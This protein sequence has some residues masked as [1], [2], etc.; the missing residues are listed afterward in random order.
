MTQVEVPGR[1]ERKKA[2][3]RAR[4]IEEATA[5]FRQRGYQATTIEDI[6]EAADVAPR[7]FY[8]YFDAKVDVALAQFEEWAERHYEAMAARPAGETPV[9]MAQ[10]ALVELARMGYVTSE[11]LRDEH[12]IPYP[13]IAAAVV[14]SETEPEVAGRMYQVLM[15]F[16]TKMTELFRERLG[17]PLG[18]IEPRIIATSMSA[19]WFVAIYGFG[20]VCASDGEPSSLDPPSLD[21]LGLT[22]LRAYSAGLERLWAGRLGDSS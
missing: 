7:T 22:G 3:T 8:S 5:L 18:A 2:A 1:R 13:P 21:E 20:D 19:T 16:Q 4:I 9:E 10:G 11:R 6:T 14:L 15:G 17:Y 12:G